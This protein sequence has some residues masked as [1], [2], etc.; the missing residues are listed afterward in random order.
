MLQNLKLAFRRIWRDKSITLINLLGLTTGLAV[1][2][3]L[4]NYVVQESTYDHHHAAADRTYKVVSRYKS[5]QEGIK[6][7]SITFGSLADEYPSNF[8]QVDYAALFYGPFESSVDV[9]QSRFNGLQ[10]LYADYSIMDIFDLPDVD[11]AQFSSSYSAIL[12]LEA[13][14]RLF[15]APSVPNEEI[16]VEG[17]RFEVSA[18]IDL[19]TNTRFQ[20]DVLLPLTSFDDLAIFK[21]GGLEFE[22]FVVLNE[23][24]NNSETTD[25]LAEHYNQLMLAKWPQFTPDNFLI[26]LKE[27]YLN[28]ES[29]RS[30]FGNGNGQMLLV[31]V[32]LAVVIFTLA[33]INYL[34]LQIAIN[35]RRA[36]ATKI[37]KVLGASRMMLVKQSMIESITVISLAAIL[38]LFF[39]QG[40][41]HSDL[42]S[43]LGKHILTVDSWSVTAYLVY[44]AV[45]ILAGLLAGLVPGLKSFSDLETGAKQSKSIQIG[46]L[47]VSMVVFQFFV[48]AC[49]IS[50]IWV[51]HLQMDFLREQNAG[52]NNE[53]V[54][55]LPN[56]TESIKDNYHIIQQQL[57]T[58]PRI[59]SIAGAQTSPGRGAS[60]QFVRRKGAAEEEQQTISHIRSV[61]GYV[62]TLGLEL[63]RGT[64]FSAKRS[65]PHQEFILNQR[66]VKLL[67]GEDDDPIGQM[68]DLSGRSGVVVGVVKDFHYRSYHH[69][70]APLILNIE[71]SY[72]LTMMLRVSNSSL[73]ETL[74]QIEQTFRTVD[75]KYTLDYYFLDEHFDHQYR[76]ELRIQQLLGQ[77]SVV[78]MIISLFG[79]LG[80]SIFVIQ[81]RMKEMAIRKTLGAGLS[82]IFWQLSMRLLRWIG[83][84]Y[85]LAVPVVYWFSDDW[86]QNFVYRI[87][88]DNLLWLVPTGSA[89]MMIAAILTIS[90]YLHQAVTLNPVKFLRNQ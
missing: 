22:T 90:Y 4:I 67:F 81:A 70:V 65:G 75:P 78:A 23:S 40:Y 46:R 59:A 12:S 21:Q 17:Q 27:A 73:Q 60:G 77:A 44:S 16:E 63:V 76:S 56:L 3:I 26:P 52:Y 36:Q 8:P 35:H 29:G 9:A 64:D 34:N 68:L 20:F 51:I 1:T 30:R 74:S 37:K 58:N 66:A 19:P 82:H 62:K 55:V 2:I 80:L 57:V 43:M 49:L 31:L 85:V 6:T 10:V 11:K 47:T 61:D 84:G 42:S 39:V 88:L 38:S 83:L 53:N 87:S 15:G 28:D 14:Q 45:L 71:E 48:T 54:L 5:S 24:S 13:T 86:T 33:L 41:Y 50:V 89:M 72:N 18:V 25:L 69:R 32:T 7:S 79:L